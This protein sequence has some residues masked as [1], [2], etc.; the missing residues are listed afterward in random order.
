[1]DNSEI[2]T[3]M[4]SETHLKIK[5]EEVLLVLEQML[6]V[7]VSIATT[8]N[9]DK[10]VDPGKS[11]GVEKNDSWLKPFREGGPQEETTGQTFS[12]R[13]RHAQPKGGPGSSA[14]SY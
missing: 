7:T 12:K 3:M 6:P 4:E 8:T 10:L 9:Q 5:V 1:M 14:S 11:A 2:L 13:G